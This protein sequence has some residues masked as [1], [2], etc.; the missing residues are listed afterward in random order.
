M[1][2]STTIAALGILT[3]LAGTAPALAQGLPDLTIDA[4]RLAASVDLVTRHF[5]RTNCAV[6]E[7]CAATGTRRLLRFDTATPNF[8]TADLVLGDPAANPELYEFSSCHKH[9]H[10]RSYTSYAL[11]DAAGQIVTGRKQAF[12]L[13]DVVQYWSGYPRHYSNCT[14]QGLSVGWADVY[15]KSLDCQWLD[16]SGV[17]TGSY[18]LEVTVDPDNL[19]AE[20]D[21]SNNV[22]RIPV[23]I[24]K[25][26]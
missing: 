24:G 26:R 21:E 20:T 11:Y 8:G 6:V 3:C 15:P 16:V 9:Y 4:S 12:C 7:G 13:I 2:K 25:S 19:I 18:V 1:A 17:R 22:A 5:K 10:L 14:N 23:T